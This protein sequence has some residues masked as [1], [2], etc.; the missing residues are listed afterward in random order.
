MNV[1]RLLHL[2]TILTLTIG[3]TGLLASAAHPHTHSPDPPAGSEPAGGFAPTAGDPSPPASPVKLI[4]IHHSCGENW[5]ADDDGGLGIALRDNKYF[6]SDTNYGWGPDS[7]GDNTDI[8]H[9]WT[10]FRG[11]GSSTYLS[12]LYTEYGQ[13]SWYSR[14][15]TDP[16]GENEIIMFKSCYPNSYLEG[17]TSPP[18]GDPNPLRGQAADSGY[19]TVANAKGI[20]NDLLTY[21]ATRQ[22]RLF[23]VITAP[24]QMESETDAAHAANARAFN[25]WLVNDWLI[26]YAHSNVAVF[27]FYN[28]LTSNGG[29]TRTDDPNTNDLGWADG[30]HHRWLTDTVQHTQTVSN[31]Y[32][33]YWG[34]NGGGSH[35]T[36]AGNQKA[37]A[38][39]VPLLNVFYNRW[40]SGAVAPS[41]TLTAPNGGENW[42][43]G[44]EQEIRWTSTGTITQVSLAYSTD[45]FSTTHVISSP[46]ANTG[47]YTW[48][49]PLTPTTSAQVR[50]AS[51]SSPTIRSTSGVFT[52][53]DP[54]TFTNIVYLPVV[55]R[56]YAPSTPTDGTLIQPADLVYL[57][58]FR[59][60]D[61]PGTP[62]NVGW[63]WSNWA[64]GLTYY[65]DGDPD[66]PA[67]GFPGSIFGIG[68]DQTQYV[69][70][71]NI[72]IPIISPGKNVN[73]LNTAETRQDF[74]DI[75]GGLFGYMEMPR[76]GLAYLPPQ[77]EQTT[78]KLYFAWAPH[79]DEGATNSSHGWCELNLSDPQPAGVWR[80]GDYWNYVTGDYLF[81][82]PQAWADSYTPGQYL[83][84]GRFR[85]GGQ[86]AEG[87]SLFAI[88]PWNEGNPPISGTVLAATPLLLYGN[89]YEENPP[90]MND[91]HHSDEW[92]GGAWLTAGDKAAVIFVGTKG[93]G[94]CWYGCADGTDEPP[95]PPD[96]DRGWW[97]S[98]FV[99]QILFY[100]PADLAAVAGEEMETWEPQPY[101]TLEIDKYL[102]HVEST[103]QKYHLGAA[104]F[105]RERGLLY[106]FEPLSDEDKP[107][108]HVWRVE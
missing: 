42:P 23:V 101:A 80:I 4:F 105:D 16:G 85:D 27:D 51:V 75:R 93:Q 97:S 86:G 55:L 74:R 52:L 61:S 96:C 59:L 30:N 20:Y 68:H 106:A 26:G 92:S 7:I 29:S 47:V 90:A 71:I 95:W 49:T 91:Y 89:A 84:T 3:P 35:P 40:T 22:D 63:E 69:S 25:N 104:S 81:A 77:G 88:G 65:P 39:F 98:T 78:G 48:T 66:G 58:V 37:T 45:G 36:A 99:G 57:G 100:D 41:L 17:P 2:I 43:V 8:G 64:S 82:T 94:D 13:H 46:V 32:A 38:E 70:E 14:L 79:L 15:S 11:P 18:T 76:V 83:A 9:W 60:P 107:L 33:A 50:V 67:D 34:G 54:S 19:H 1:K 44:T 103:Q 31:N 5:L 6:V 10:W 62:D 24:P 12:A 28:V 87:P 53:Y 21:F 73:D 72:P 108:I 56:N 102:Y